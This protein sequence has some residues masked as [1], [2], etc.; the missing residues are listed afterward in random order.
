M[1]RVVNAE[2]LP[3]ARDAPCPACGISLEI[4]AVCRDPH[5]DLPAP[6]DLDDTRLREHLHVACPG[7]GWFG[8]MQPASH[9][10]EDAA[11]VEPG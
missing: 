5:P 10:V 4:R 9:H 11:G 3:F 7:C 8:Y 6:S 2:I 1:V